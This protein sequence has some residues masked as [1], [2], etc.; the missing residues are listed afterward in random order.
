ML[1]LLGRRST[2]S[3]PA[4]S[5]QRL[6]L[7]PQTYNTAEYLFQNAEGSGRGYVDLTWS[8]Y[9]KPLLFTEIGLG[10]DKPNH[11]SVVKGQLQGCVDYN[12]R[13]PDRLAG[14]CFFQFADKVWKQGSSEGVFGA[15][16]ILAVSLPQSNTV[17]AISPIGTFRNP[18]LTR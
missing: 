10:R 3:T 18:L 4:P 14:F 2:R 6:F 5:P 9:Q 15:H 17:R 16:S 7:A 11:V 8:R 13:Y 1:G 12:K